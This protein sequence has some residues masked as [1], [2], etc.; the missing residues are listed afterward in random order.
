MCVCRF[1]GVPVEVR[2]KLAGVGSL[3]APPGFWGS[4][5][6]GGTDLVAMVFSL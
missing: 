2:G 4:K 5:E 1:D 3:L 6:G